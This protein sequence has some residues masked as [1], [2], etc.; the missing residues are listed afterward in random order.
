MASISDDPNGRR[1]ILFVAP[2]G[3]RKTLRLGKLDRK[4]AEAI[5]RHVEALLS[6][7]IG[8]QPVPRDTASWI[9]AIGDELKSKLSAVGLLEAPRREAL[10]DFL[11]GYILNRADVKPA[12]LEVWRQPCRNLIALFGDDKPLKRITA[13]DAEQFRQWITTQP[14]AVATI[15]KRLSFCRT[16][17]HVARKHRMIDENPFA[18]VKIPVADVTARQHFVDRPT[19]DKLMATASPTWQTILAL[20][21]YGGLRCPSEVL[22]LEWKHV[23]FVANTIRVPSPKTER[24]AGKASRELPMFPELRQ[25]LE[26]AYELAD[27][28]QTHVVGGGHL[29]KADGERGW[30]NCNLR[31]SFSKLIRRAGL[32]PW[33]R[34]FHNLRSSRETELLDRFPVQVVSKWMGHDPKTCLAHYAQTTDDHFHRAVGGAESGA[35]KAQKPAQQ[36]VAGERAVSHDVGATPC[37]TGSYASPGDSRRLAAQTK[38]G[39]GGIR[40]HGRTSPTSVFKTDAIDHSATPP[41]AGAL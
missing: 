31:T 38:N 32:A 4:S 33:P 25:S 19:I 40:T 37:E 26:A 30:G 13:G 36:G 35:R 6:A 17:F 8:G 10:G 2:D 1:R 3:S 9:T 41:N 18:D 12:T 15:A 7:K 14:L 28:D 34:L 5:N 16:F 23:D 22:S 11:R 20:S 29:A 39:G 24:Y 27:P 21:R